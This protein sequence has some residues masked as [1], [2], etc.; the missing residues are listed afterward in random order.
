MPLSYLISNIPSETVRLLLFGLGVLSGSGWIAALRPG[1]RDAFRRGPPIRSVFIIDTTSSAICHHCVKY[2]LKE[3]AGVCGG[4][5][6]MGFESTL[7]CN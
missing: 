7:G 1:L 2:A 6:P 4:R 3:D 5:G